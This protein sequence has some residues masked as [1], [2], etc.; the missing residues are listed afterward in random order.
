MSMKTPQNDRRVPPGPGQESVWNYPRPP[1]VERMPARI[2]VR[3][4]GQV[5]V[6][7]G[8]AVRVLETSHPPVFYLPI[9]DFAPGVLEPVEGTTHCEFKGAAAYFDVVAGA[10]RSLRGAWTYP[11]PVR[12]YEDLSTRAAIYPSQMDSCSVDGEQVQAQEG[13]F[14]GGWITSAV[15]GPFKGAAGTWGW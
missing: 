3:F 10:A 11:S 9:E 8:N 14:Y 6:R 5:I 1:R 2:E 15:V 4:G 7:T 13:D 12:G